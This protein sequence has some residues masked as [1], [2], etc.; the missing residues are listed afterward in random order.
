MLVKDGPGW[1][2]SGF[3][4]RWPKSFFIFFSMISIQGIRF[5]IHGVRRVSKLPGNDA[6]HVLEG[7]KGSLRL[8]QFQKV[9]IEANIS[10]NIQY[11]RSQHLAF[12]LRFYDSAAWA[13]GLSSFEMGPSLSLLSSFCITQDCYLRSS[14]VSLL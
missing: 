5:Q 11:L 14:L 7:F 9:L 3:D 4:A 13:F 12:Q 6:K 10:S 1:S 2:R 8:Q